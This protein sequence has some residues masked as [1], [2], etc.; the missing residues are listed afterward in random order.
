MTAILPRSRWI[1]QVR[2]TRLLNPFKAMAT[3]DGPEQTLEFK[4]I[5]RSI[6]GQ[7][8]VKQGEFSRVSGGA[9]GP[10]GGVIPPLYGG[11]FKGPRGAPPV[12]RRY[13]LAREDL[14]SPSVECRVP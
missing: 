4:V 1:R 13:P 2:E 14:A 9:G 6:Q 3:R 12:S 8:K 10:P 11:P 7:F 5:S